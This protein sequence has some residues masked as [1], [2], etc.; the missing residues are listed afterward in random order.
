MAVSMKMIAFWDMSSCMQRVMG[1]GILNILPREFRHPPWWYFRLRNS[2]IIILLW[3]P[4][5]LYIFV[6]FNTGVMLLK[7]TLTPYFLIP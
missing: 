1:N 6:K 4:V 5:T 3:V 7:V 2:V